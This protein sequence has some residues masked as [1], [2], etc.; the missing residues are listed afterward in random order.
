MK[1]AY[2]GA[3]TAKT[4]RDVPGRGPRAGRRQA[5]ARTERLVE[6]GFTTDVDVY[7]L[8][9]KRGELEKNINLADKT[10]DARPRRPWRT[11]TG[12]P[13]GVA[14]DADRRGPAGGDEDLRALDLFVEDARA[15]RPE[16][17]QLEQGIKARRNLVEVERKQGYPLFFVGLLG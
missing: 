9:S 10:I 6:G 15:G 2:W 7:R 4:I 16:F 13:K 14:V 1:Q 5:I 12:Q 17:T 11:W 8:R 3:V